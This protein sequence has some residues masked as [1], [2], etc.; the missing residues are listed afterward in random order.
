MPTLT[1]TTTQSQADRIAAAL[2]DELGTVDQNNA[3]RSATAA[4]VKAEV[5]RWLRDR[6]LHQE[7]S[8]AARAAEAGVPD[9]T[10]T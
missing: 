4:E 9:L 8:V 1:I 2:G 7:Q 10:P 5:I 6:V 3:P